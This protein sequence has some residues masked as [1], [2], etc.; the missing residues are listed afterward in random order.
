MFP[1][2]GK[3][4]LHQCELQ[5]GD[6]LYL[7]PHWYHDPCPTGP[8]AMMTVRCTPPEETWGTAQQREALSRA[9]LA[10][11]ECLREFSP[12]ARASYSALLSHDLAHELYARN[13]PRPSD[14]P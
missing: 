12:T 8:N 10:L 7:P 4:T 5:P 1:L 14:D 9:A 13:T 2:F 6:V 3:A 11:Y